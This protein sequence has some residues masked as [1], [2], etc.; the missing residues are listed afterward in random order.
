MVI[1]DS[2]Q[3]SNH[4]KGEMEKYMSQSLVVGKDYNYIENPK[5]KAGETPLIKKIIIKIF[6]I[7]VYFFDFML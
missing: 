1:I 2:E 5:I 7:V 3:F 4:L 6:S